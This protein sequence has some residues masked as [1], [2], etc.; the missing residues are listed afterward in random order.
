MEHFQHLLFKFSLFLCTWRMW[1][2]RHAWKIFHKI[3]NFSF[4]TFQ[5]TQPFQ[6]RPIRTKER[7]IWNFEYFQDF[8]SWF[9][10][11]HEGCNSPTQ[12]GKFLEIKDFLRTLNAPFFRSIWS[13]LEWLSVLKSPET[14][15]YD[16]MKKK[17][18]MSHIPHS[19]CT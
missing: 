11:I 2:M 14:K 10:W 13:I 7:C 4:W 19:S 16:F 1:Y 9:D 12:R 18:C 15:V 3:I 6:N 17:S 8:M 5:N